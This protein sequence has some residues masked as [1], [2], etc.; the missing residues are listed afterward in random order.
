MLLSGTFFSVTVF[1]QWLQNICYWLP[2]TQF[3]DAM[4]RLSFEGLHL[5]DCWKQI[6]ILGIWIA[7]VYI[8]LVRV[9]RWE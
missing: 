5:Y 2:L 6:G 1:P 4:R 8:I 9:I 3:N 7:I